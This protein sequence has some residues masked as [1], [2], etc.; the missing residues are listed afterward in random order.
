MLAGRP[1]PK[2]C[3]DVRIY[4]RLPVLPNCQTTA[5]FH[6][7]EAVVDVTTAVVSE[8]WVLQ[9][10]LMFWPGGVER[11]QAPT[12]KSVEARRPE[13]IN[14][15]LMCLFGLFSDGLYNVATD[16]VHFVP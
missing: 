2:Y 3:L 7:H 6:H 12:V 4:G 5:S 10:G 11:E 15:G 14:R 16:F 13:L 1:S 8:R 9:R